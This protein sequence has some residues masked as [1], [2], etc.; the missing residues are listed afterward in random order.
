[1]LS[2]GVDALT[3]SER[4]VADLAARGLT[5]RE[6]A[7]TLFLATRT[8]E[9]HLAHTYQKLAIGGRRELAARLGPAVPAQR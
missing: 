2:G 9:T 8:V 5:N 1:M 3:V 4:R 6:I 7:Q